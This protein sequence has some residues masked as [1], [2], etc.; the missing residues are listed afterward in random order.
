MSLLRWRS[1]VRFQAG[2]CTTPTPTTAT[3]GDALSEVTAL[4]VHGKLEEALEYVESALEPAAESEKQRSLAAIAR[5]DLLTLLKQGDGDVVAEYRRAQ[6]LQPESPF[7]EFALG[8]LM[9]RKGELEKAQGHLSAAL[10]KNYTSRPLERFPPILEARTRGMLGD[11]EHLLGWDVAEE[12]REAGEVGDK[13][14]SGVVKMTM[15]DGMMPEDVELSYWEPSVEV[16]Q[17]VEEGAELGTMETDKICVSFDALEAGVVTRV[18]PTV[19]HPELDETLVDVLSLHTGPSTL[20]SATP[21]A[22]GSYKERIGSVEE[23]AALVKEMVESGEKAAVITGA[24]LSVGAKLPTRK[25]MWAREDLDRETCVTQWEVLRNPEGLWD[26]T[27]AFYEDVAD[28]LDENGNLPPTEAHTVLATM[29]RDG[30]VGAILTQ[31]VDGLHWAAACKVDPKRAYTR[32]D[33]VELHGRLDQTRCLSCG[34]Q[35]N[36]TRYWYT[37]TRDG[38]PETLSAGVCS[39]TVADSVM[40]GG[41]LIPNVVLFGGAVRSSDLAAAVKA[42]RSAPLLF[43]VGTALDASPTADLPLLAAANGT[44]V[45][46]INIEP[47]RLT[48]IIPNSILLQGDAQDVLPQLYDCITHT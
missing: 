41:P 38:L 10:A 15:E 29:A 30:L 48:N 34:A 33:I 6:E 25:D 47:T 24:G 27:R 11:V 5:G 12:E 39:A 7:P 20:A 40:C 21:V 43:V 45:V 22:H 18:E 42:V 37:G 35:K 32:A 13:V 16:G 8:A 1:L 28:D 14:E 9:R 23:V 26:A 2:Y 44:R 17:E 3:F 31:N 4:R 46:E 19:S 36:P